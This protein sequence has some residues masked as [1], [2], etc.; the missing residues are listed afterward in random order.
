METGTLIQWLKKEGD[1]VSAGDAIASVQTDKTTIDWSVTD[2]GYIA[3]ILV[4][5]GS[6]DIPVGGKPCVIIVEEE[7]DIAAFKDYSADESAP[8]KTK[9]APKKED[10][11]KEAS[12][13]ED[14]PKQ[15][16]ASTK[17]EPPTPEAYSSTV[18]SGAPPPQSE[19]KPSRILASPL[20]K[21]L[22]NQLG[23]DISNISGSGPGGRITASDLSK[24]KSGSSDS[25]SSSASSYE[26]INASSVRKTTAKRLTESKQTVPHYY[27]TI[28]CQV[29]QLM[30]TR[31]YLNEKANGKYKI[32]VNDFVLKAS[33]LALKEVPEC[34]SHWMG[35]FIRKYIFFFRFC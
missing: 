21:N 25:S 14:S 31:A 24:G 23:I 2:E 11:K 9:E 32:S 19:T 35:S 28:E 4:P 34:N 7:K 17:A 10:P 3:K 8:P 20:A 13:K 6:E 22:A 1:K 27:L 33:A 5:E 30:K 15:P 12:K 16:A 18:V 29:D 26:D